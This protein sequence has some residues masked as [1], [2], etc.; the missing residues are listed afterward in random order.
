MAS[1]L[2]CPHNRVE[3]VIHRLGEH[4]WIYST[5]QE[6]GSEWTVEEVVVDLADIVSADE[7]VEVHQQLETGKPLKELI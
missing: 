7:I 5:C 2:Q 3:F 4:R 6:C 1:K